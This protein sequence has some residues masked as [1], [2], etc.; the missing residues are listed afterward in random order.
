MRHIEAVRPCC[1]SQALVISD[2]DIQI[3]A[4]VQCGGQ[5]DRIQRPHRGRLKPTGDAEQRGRDFD[6]GQPVED[7]PD[8]NKQIWIDATYGPHQFGAGKVAGDRW[9]ITAVGDPATQR[10]GL[11]LDHDELGQR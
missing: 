9:H 5:M 10:L 7:F 8:T 3:V 4:E 6:D 1:C 11:V 2:K